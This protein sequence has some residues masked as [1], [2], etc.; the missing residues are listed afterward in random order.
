MP[1]SS[2]L[3]AYARLLKLEPVGGEFAPASV[4][5]HSSS[6]SADVPPKRGMALLSFIVFVL[7]PL[8][9]VSGYFWIFAVDRYV[10]EATF[11]L[12]MPGRAISNGQISSLMQTAG[13]S[14]AGDDSHIV[15]EYLVSRDALAWAKAQAGFRSML[16]LANRDP[17]WRFPNFWSPDAE[18][19][20]F[21]QYER[22]VSAS[23]DGASGLN[24]LKVQAFSP[25]DAKRLASSLLDAAEAMVNKLNERA[26]RDA[27][28]LAEGEVDRMRERAIVAQAAMT[29]FRESERFVDPSQLTLAVLETIAKLSM[30]AAQVNVQL[31]ELAQASPN[32]PHIA[33]L[34]IRR[35]ALEAQI[36]IERQ[37]LAG[38]AQ[39]IAPRIA[40]Y[41]QLMLEREF[42]EKALMAAMASV[43]MARAE[44]LR[45]QVYLERVSVPTAPDYPA[46]PWRIVWCLVT[47]VAGYMAWRMWVAV[48]GDALKHNER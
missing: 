11:V 33:S 31:G 28:A 7:L 36:L 13:I 34:R 10:S 18:E 35:A 3:N 38:D 40:K 15:Q 30:E 45:Q 41:E 44:A 43:E 27:I 37:K 24:T 12:R 48:A 26:R 42:A 21:W 32:A 14:R 46:Y 23:Y 9:A 39:A 16:V 2:T 47:A 19:G 22:M 8:L 25:P 29:N 20:L 4:A 17:F 1:N 5:P 6:S